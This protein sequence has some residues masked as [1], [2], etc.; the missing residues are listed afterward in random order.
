MIASEN[1]N[2]LYISVCE[3]IRRTKRT[4]DNVEFWVDQYQ[5]TAG[6]E[7]TDEEAQGVVDQI[8]KVFDIK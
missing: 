2:R 1:V 5:G 8:K 4:V 7:V 6:H 3:V